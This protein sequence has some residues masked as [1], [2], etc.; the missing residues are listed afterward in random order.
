MDGLVKALWRCF[1]DGLVKAPGRWFMDS[2]VKIL[3]ELVT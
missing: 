1:R 3:E 2:L